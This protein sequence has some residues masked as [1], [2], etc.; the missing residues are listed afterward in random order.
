MA[1]VKIPLQSNLLA[2]DILTVLEGQTYVLSF[3]FNRR[4]QIWQMDI[5]DV[6]NQ[7]ILNGLPM[8]TQTDLTLY[9][10]NQG[11]PPGIFYVFDTEG[12]KDNPSKSNFG[13]RYLLLYEESV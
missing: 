9:N 13:L 8:L 7:P 2:Y 10:S 3:A 5:N 1:I 4:A 12:S 11:L 6:N